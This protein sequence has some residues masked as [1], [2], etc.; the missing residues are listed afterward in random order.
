[1]LA[2]NVVSKVTA[3]ISCVIYLIVTPT[4]LSNIPPT[5]TLVPFFCSILLLGHLR[6]CNS[7]CKFRNTTIHSWWSSFCWDVMTKN[8]HKWAIQATQ[9]KNKSHCMA[10]AAI[11]SWLSTVWEW[12]LTNSFYL[13]KEWWERKN[14]PAL[15]VDKNSQL[16]KLALNTLELC[17]FPDDAFKAMTLVIH[18]WR[19]SWKRTLTKTES[20]LKTQTGTIEMNN[21]VAQLKEKYTTVFNSRMK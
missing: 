8:S 18:K 13:Y 16:E 15:R 17:E 4:T 6:L 19:N 5:K 1:M 7:H 10:F 21:I 3:L 20:I 12:T 9:L 11:N 2:I 14:I